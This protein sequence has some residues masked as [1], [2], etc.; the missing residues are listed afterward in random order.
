M[1]SLKEFNQCHDLLHCPNGVV[2]LR[3]KEILPHSSKYKF[4][5]STHVNY[6]P[7]AKFE[8]WNQ[9][10]D[11]ISCGNKDL[12]KYCQKTDGY[13]ATGLIREQIGF[14][15]YGRRG[16]NGKTVK[17]EAINKAL[18]DYAKTISY[19][20]LTLNPKGTNTTYA[21]G[22][23]SLLGIRRVTTDEVPE[24]SKMNMTEF[25][26]RVSDQVVDGRGIYRAED[27][28][29]NTSKYFILT[30]HTLY[31]GAQAFNVT[32]RI[33]IR[34]YNL[35]LDREKIDLD[36]PF[37]FGTREALE[38]IL[39][40]LV[41]G[42]YLY[43][44]EG[45]ETPPAVKT[46][47]NEFLDETDPLYGLIDEVIERHEEAF[48][49]K[50]FLP[51]ETLYDYFINVHMINYGVKNLYNLQTF[52]RLVSDALTEKYPDVEKVRRKINGKKLSGYEG[53]KMKDEY[54]IKVYT[55]PIEEIEA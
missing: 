18:G 49:V 50:G 42:A 24:G 21:L 9:F 40:Y 20:N 46:A 23:D 32:R 3:T 27:S 7:D 30:N 12:A 39:A 25:K 54:F 44:N 52:G 8:R 26:K 4:T 13:S 19:V 14:F 36:L 22:I 38:A 15:D 31:L 34:P 5:L 37:K 2:D 28:Y 11:E 51:L 29:P 35:V 43:L 10:M 17:T 53:I 33:R 16:G 6:D 47:T 48:D 41:E 1:I 45:L 55:L